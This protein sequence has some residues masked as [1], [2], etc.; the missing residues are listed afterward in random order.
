M[1]INSSSSDS[2]GVVVKNE[3]NIGFKQP[4]MR[5]KCKVYTSF[6]SFRT[7]ND[8]EVALKREFEGVR[9]HY[10]ERK[11]QVNDTKIYYKCALGCPKRLYIRLYD[12]RDGATIYISEDEH[13]HG[14]I[15]NKLTEETMRKVKEL[16]DL[17][18]A[19][20]DIL[21]E[22]RSLGIEQITDQQLKNFKVY[23]LVYRK[24]TKIN[25]Y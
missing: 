17:D 9:W 23:T 6:V 16:I 4:K 24:I 8:A 18:F 20:R 7:K 19:N 1:S 15:R 5:G 3:S 21:R 14:S 11:N 22:I 12:E 2:K 25:F 13:N 10:H